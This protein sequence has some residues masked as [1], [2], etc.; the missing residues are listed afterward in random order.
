M[1]TDRLVVTI[2]YLVIIYAAGFTLFNLFNNYFAAC[3]LNAIQTLIS[4]F[5]IYLF[6][7]GFKGL[8]KFLLPFTSIIIVFLYHISF[9]ADTVAYFYYL[10]IIVLSIA[11]FQDEGR[12]YRYLISVISLASVFIL[13]IFNLKWNAI[14]VS[15]TE[16]IIIKILN[17]IGPLF[18]TINVLVFYH[19]FNLSL[20]KQLND[21]N[22]KY[23]EL[24]SR[25][26]KS[27]KDKNRLFALISH[28]LRSPLSTI[29]SGLRLIGDGR[30]KE[31]DA[32]RVITSLQYRTNQ[33]IELLND[34][35]LW[36]NMDQKEFQYK[37]VA[38]DINELMRKVK[39]FSSIS[40]SDKQ[41]GI[42][43]EEASVACCL[44]DRNMLEAVVRNLVSNAIKF[45]ERNSYI[46]IRANTEFDRCRIEV[47][48]SGIGIAYE[49]IE[50]IT[51]NETVSTEGSEHEK[52]FGFGLKLCKDFLQYHGAT[53]DIESEPGLGTKVGFW[54]A[55]ASSDGA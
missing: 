40:A 3:W 38:N 13:I 33:T 28:D 4:L 31:S 43:I 50:K 26:D 48:D 46:V 17:I 52:G 20:L 15:E 41:I 54:L 10:P 24:I 53:L 6:R 8:A 39:E 29:S 22:D 9:Q 55:L 1:K 32:E 18:I 37:P 35:F 12:W 51:K 7:K 23:A 25:L 44:C 5:N 2:N 30:V 47:V 36:I 14:E 11:F 19:K 16:L 34:L 45:S 42:V 27:I 49:L 21:R